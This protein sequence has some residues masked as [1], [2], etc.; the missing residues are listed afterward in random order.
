MAR[1]QR[2]TDEQILAAAREVF[3]RRGIQATTADVARR[4]RVAEGS[5]FNR[6]R[7][8]QQLFRAAMRPELADPPWLASLTR[9]AG[10]G[11][12]REILIDVGHEILAFFRRLMP[13]MMMSWSNR[14][15]GLPDDLKAPDSPP[16]RAL[17]RLA[18]F[19]EAEMRAGRIRRHDP[20]ILARA[21][22][23]SLQNYVVFEL[24][25][26]A[27]DELP[28]PSE[29]YLRGLVALLWEGA[30]PRTAGKQK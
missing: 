20:E 1:P 11:D 22:L 6:F 30:S 7:T 16:L 14:G 8:K 17:K 3:L 25:L 23:G 5:I 19:F 9:R 29:T 4:A 18:G 28:L 12:V 21:Y 10:K 15:R 2:I 26:K 27:R 24:L 13:L